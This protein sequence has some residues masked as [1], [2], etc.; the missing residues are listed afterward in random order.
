M[1]TAS[2]ALSGL[3][4]K[5]PVR[6]LL[7]LGRD[8]SPETVLPTRILYVHPASRCTRGRGRDL[9]EAPASGITVNPYGPAVLAEAMAARSDDRLRRDRMARN[10]RRVPREVVPTERIADRRLGAMAESHQPR[11][12]PARP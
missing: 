12:R 7:P 4:L 3:G 5:L 8:P 1:E 10:A 6:R 2:A 11:A 9:L